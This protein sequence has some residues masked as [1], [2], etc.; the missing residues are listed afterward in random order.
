MLFKDDCCC[1]CC[2]L[3]VLPLLTLC[4]TLHFLV[5]CCCNRSH[6]VVDPQTN[7]WRR[8]HASHRPYGRWQVTVSVSELNGWRASLHHHHG[9]RC[10]VFCCHR[11]FG[12]RFEYHTILNIF[13]FKIQ[14][15]C[16]SRQRRDAIACAGS[17]WQRK[18]FK[19]KIFK[20]AIKANAMGV[21]ADVQQSPQTIAAIV[22]T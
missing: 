10:I 11:S 17:L 8:H 2:Y 13:R 5:F 19:F 21:A 20:T 3:F 18:S 4:R 9:R 1:C 7:K 15:L 16:W 22:Q 14:K 12:L 6:C